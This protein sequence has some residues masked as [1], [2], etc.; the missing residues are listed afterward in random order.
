M[1]LDM[2]RQRLQDQEV[3]RARRNLI[4]IQ[5]TPLQLNKNL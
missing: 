4:S 1:Q 3:K 2:P 5:T